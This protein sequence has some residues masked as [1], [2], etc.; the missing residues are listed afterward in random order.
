MQEDPQ[1]MAMSY[2]YAATAAFFSHSDSKSQQ[3]TTA[4][5]IFQ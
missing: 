1:P 4:A 3:K 5:G 2:C